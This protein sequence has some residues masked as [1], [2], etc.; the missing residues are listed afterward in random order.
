M[1]AAACDMLLVVACMSQR[2]KSG[3][4]KL[5]LAD[6]CIARLPKYILIGLSVPARHPGVGVS[7][8]FTCQDRATR[9]APQNRGRA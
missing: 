4:I 6:Y 2:E 7:P 5:T 8:K 9:V 1:P 3:Q